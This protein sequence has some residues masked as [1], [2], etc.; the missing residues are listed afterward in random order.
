MSI[1]IK[2]LTQA[3]A[4]PASDGRVAENAAVRSRQEPQGQEGGGSDDRV[5]LTDTARRLSDLASTVSG[6]PPVDRGRVDAIRAAI[7]D[8][9]YEVKSD[10]VAAG[11]LT[12]EGRGR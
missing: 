12:M 8:G 11:L 9:S 2:N 4:R 7:Q 5:T 1:D 6:Q 3:Q 10:R